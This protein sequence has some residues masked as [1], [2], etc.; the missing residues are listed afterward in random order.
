M[1]KYVWLTWIAVA[2]VPRIGFAGENYSGIWRTT[3]GPMRL[4]QQK[5][6]V[7]GTYLVDGTACRIAGMLS[8]KKLTFT[9]KEPDAAGEG[10]FE[11]NSD[12]S[13]FTGKWRETGET[14]W[15]VWKGTR[16][17]TNRKSDTGFDGDFVEGDFVK[18]L[19][20]STFGKL[21]LIQQKDGSI[22]GIYEL[23]SGSSLQGAVQGNRLTFHY[24]EPTAKGEGWFEFW[25][26]GRHFVGKWR[27]DGASEWSD[28]TGQRVEPVTG[29]TWLVVIEARWEASLSDPQ[30]TF[31]DM[32]GTFFAPAENVQVRQRIFNDE[33]D[34]RKWLSSVAF[35]AE[36]VVVVVAAHGKSKGVVVDGLTI[37]SQAFA[38]ALRFAPN[39]KLVHFSSCRMM[40]GH[41][42]EQLLDALGDR[43]KFSV[44]GYTTTVDWELSAISDF[45]YLDMVLSRDMSPAE[46]AARLPKI[47]P[48]AGDSAAQKVKVRP[49]GF[50]LVTPH[51][52]HRKP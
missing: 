8:G 19:W 2:A 36:P 18:G 40:K 25:E 17:E 33:D 31:G 22:Q 29:R 7:S 45:L 34:L 52:K 23:V 4:L 6:Q 50:R 16:V 24:R 39:V 14:A 47:M 3:F 42:A 5:D 35:L 1:K 10:W 28:W 51:A 15:D 20:D 38:D 12:G 37:D 49:L 21:R 43:A 46:A 13:K 11:L 30:Y 44:S 27:P 41:F 48:I 9:Y 32:L 26:D